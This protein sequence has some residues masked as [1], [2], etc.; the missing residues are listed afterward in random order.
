[1]YI[2]HFGPLD[3]WYQDYALLV[4]GATF[5]QKG[6][7]TPFNQAPEPGSFTLLGLGGLIALRRRRG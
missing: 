5:I 4:T 6:S 2:D 1:L 3:D 7:Y